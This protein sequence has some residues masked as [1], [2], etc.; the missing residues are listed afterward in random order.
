MKDYKTFD[1]HYEDIDFEKRG[2]AAWITI[3]RE[4]RGNSFRRETLD[5]IR[6]AVE[7]AGD[8][9]GVRRQENGGDEA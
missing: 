6:D 5:E 7:R 2:H 3:N 4:K 8:G 1:V 9:P